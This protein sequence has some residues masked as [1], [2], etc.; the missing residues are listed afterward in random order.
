M[1]RR[2]PWSPKEQSFCEVPL[3]KQRTQEGNDPDCH[4][5]RVERP[6]SRES[7]PLKTTRKVLIGI[8]E[9]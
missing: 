3:I 7:A 1:D 6:I 8:L 5:Y 2:I 4:R 9:A